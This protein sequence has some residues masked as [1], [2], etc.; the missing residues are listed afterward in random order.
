MSE[1]IVVITTTETQKDGEWLAHLLVERE[2]A[3]CVQVL[4]QMTSIYRWQDHVER[5]A[6]T[7]LL[8][9]T[10]REL[11]PAVETAIKTH[12]HYQTPE[13]IAL[14]IEAG[15]DDYLAWLIAAVKP[16]A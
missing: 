14:P 2:L 5:A 3:A 6:E 4:P 11:Y 10:T 15:S 12:H 9:K 16:R 7:L 1:G 8:I 13:V